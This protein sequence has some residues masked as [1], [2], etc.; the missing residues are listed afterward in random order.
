MPDV[1]HEELLEGLE[2][3]LPAEQ[4]LGYSQQIEKSRFENGDEFAP[5]HQYREDLKD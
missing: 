4:P 3:P 2:L 1:R 5:S